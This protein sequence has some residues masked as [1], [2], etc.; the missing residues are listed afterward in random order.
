MKNFLI[1]CVS[2]IFILIVA[3]VILASSIASFY[4]DYAHTDTSNLDDEKYVVYYYSENDTYSAALLEDMTNFA[5]VMTENNIGFYLVNMDKK[6]ANDME[7]KSS[8]D[9]AQ[10]GKDYPVTP[11]QANE[12]GLDNIVIAGAPELIYVENGE[13]KNMGV[14]V[15]TSTMGNSY[16]SIQD[17]L[18]SIAKQNNLEFTPTYTY[19][20]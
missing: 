9:E 11:E 6:E 16:V 17:T 7:L 1:I 10:S 4:K 8:I 12:L 20:E 18:T 2:I 19:T 13:V 3:V 5:S 15:Q 14:G